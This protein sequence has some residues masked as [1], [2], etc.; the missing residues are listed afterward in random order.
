[1]PPIWHVESRNVAS[2]LSKVPIG[3][4]AMSPREAGGRRLSQ[5]ALKVKNCDMWATN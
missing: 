5:K 4:I 2:E 3:G 1:M